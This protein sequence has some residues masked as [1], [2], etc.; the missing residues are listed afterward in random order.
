[1]AYFKNIDRFG[2][3][4]ID[5]YPPQCVQAYKASTQSIPNAVDTVVSG[6]TNQL[7][8][9]NG[10]WNATTGV[11]T[12][13]RAGYYRVTGYVQYN[14]GQAWGANNI[15]SN[16]IAKNGARYSVAF[17]SEK[18]SHNQFIGPY[19][20]SAVVQLNVGETISLTTYQGSGGARTLMGQ[21]ISGFP[22]FPFFISINEI[23]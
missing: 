9:S 21:P 11:F 17:I 18:V 5:Y 16:H 3:E 12:A 19:P 15:I 22:N 23:V 4:L 14:S 10:A 2:N 7:D 6:W 13:N 20:V 8:T 1:M